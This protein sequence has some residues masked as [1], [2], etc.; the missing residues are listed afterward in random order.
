MFRKTDNAYKI[1]C[2]RLI[3]EDHAVERLP[4]EIARLGKK[5]YLVA[6]EN[7]WAADG[8]HVSEL[9][10]GAGIPF[11]LDVYTGPCSEEKAREIASACE[12]QG[13]DIVVGLGGGRIMDLAKAS[14]NLEDPCLRLRLINVPTIAATCASYTPLSIIY[15][16]DG[17]YSHNLYFKREIDCVI[18]DVSILLRE[19][20]RYLASG[21]LD[22]MA[23]WVEISHFA[24]RVPEAGPD[25]LL[26]RSLAKGM[27]DDLKRDCLAAFAGEEKAMRNAVFHNIVTTGI[28]SGISRGAYQ[29]ALAHGLYYT[30]RGLYP[31][32][33]KPCLHGEIVAV[34][35][36]LQSLYLGNT[37]QEKAL[38][39]L[40]VRM[41][42]PLSLSDINVPTDGKTLRAFAG[43]HYVTRYYYENGPEQEGTVKLLERIR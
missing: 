29:V 38:R 32:E 22:A 34:G 7:A 41:S 28:V 27:Y 16:P 37:E 19:P 26:A 9:L 3:Y 15:S 13:C 40:M 2:G 24:Y 42:M 36:L 17:F 10:N 30:V 39:A 4:E 35:M 21:M 6:G 11:A 31:R 43:Y 33:S 23:K 18:C 14:V 5:V 1:G 12:K 25:E 20:K 8:G